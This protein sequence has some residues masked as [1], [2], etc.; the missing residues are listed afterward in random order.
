MHFSNLNHSFAYV[1]Q[2]NK[3]LKE[4]FA[5]ILES[6]VP[7]VLDLIHEIDLAFINSH[8]LIQQARIYSPNSIEIGGI[9]LRTQDDEIHQV[10]FFLKFC[11]NPI[12][13]PRENRKIACDK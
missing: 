7:N 9:Q 11:K 6:N 3:I 2:Q 8:P 10:K 12:W 4:H 5:E 1:P 13:Y